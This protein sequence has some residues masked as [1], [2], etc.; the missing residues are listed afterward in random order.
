M[1]QSM[2]L[3][4]VQRFTEAKS[5]IAWTKIEKFSSSVWSRLVA[6]WLILALPVKNLHWKYVYIISQIIYPYYYRFLQGTNQWAE[7]RASNPTL[8]VGKKIKQKRLWKWAKGVV[9]V[10]RSIVSETLNATLTWQKGI[11]MSKGR[12]AESKVVSIRLSEETYKIL[13]GI[14][15]AKALSK[16][17]LVEEYLQEDWKKNRNKYNKILCLQRGVKWTLNLQYITW[18]WKQIGI[19]SECLKL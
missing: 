6:T 10:A 5:L 3:T 18:W 16:A 15:N 8:K 19:V 4:T 7:S 14:K 1:N 13:Q 17:D 2:A 12:T 9:F 11:S